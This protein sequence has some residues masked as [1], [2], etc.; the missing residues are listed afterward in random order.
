[1]LFTYPKLFLAAG[2]GWESRHKQHLVRGT[3]QVSIIQYKHG[4]SRMALVVKTCLPMQE[5]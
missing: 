5:T 3:I 2:I 1:M 4:S